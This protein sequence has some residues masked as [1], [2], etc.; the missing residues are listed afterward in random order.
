MIFSTD[1]QILVLGIGEILLGICIL[2]LE[3][4]KQNKN[5]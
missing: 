1:I 3:H 5:K 4:K 2:L